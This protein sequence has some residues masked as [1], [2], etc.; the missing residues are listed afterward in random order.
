M[1]GFY[2]EHRNITEQTTLS[3]DLAQHIFTR[4]AF[5]SV[6]VATDK[7]HD[8]ASIT[9]KQ[10]HS[11]TRLVQRERS[12]TLQSS[13]IAE[14]S[15]QLGWMDDLTFTSKLPKELTDSI[16]VFAT[17]TDLVLRPPVC[18]TLYIA[19]ELDDKALAAI[20]KNLEETGVVIVY[21]LTKT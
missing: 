1:S 21:D 3:R 7:P 14:L 9:K 17:A 15:N 20:T 5:G 18:S 4:G 13:R 2:I 8:L 19:Q 16:V 6:I 11:L 12:S 10:W